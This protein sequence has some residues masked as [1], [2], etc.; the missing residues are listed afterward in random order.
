MI[1]LLTHV[2]EQPAINPRQPFSFCLPTASCHFSALHPCLLGSSRISVLTAAISIAALFSRSEQCTGQVRRTFSLPWM[3]AVLG[4]SMAPRLRA[5]CRR[6]RCRSSTPFSTPAEHTAK[7]SA[8]RP[9][10]MPQ[11]RSR[12][13]DSLT[14]ARHERAIGEKAERRHAKRSYGR[15]PSC[16]RCPKDLERRSSAASTPASEPKVISRTPIAALCAHRFIRWLT[17]PEGHFHGSF[18]GI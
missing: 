2:T 6:R 4:Q 15:L 10:S 16:R 9:V 8:S 17:C 18:W 5:G 3:V 7:A 12:K 14:D 11:P 1:R 13:L